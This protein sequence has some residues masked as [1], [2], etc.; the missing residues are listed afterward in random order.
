MDEMTQIPNQDYATFENKHKKAKE[1]ALTTMRNEYKGFEY[2]CI[3]YIDKGKRRGRIS[4]VYTMRKE[5]DRQY[6]QYKEQYE[7]FVKLHGCSMILRGDEIWDDRNKYITTLRVASGSGN[8][9]SQ[10]ELV[11]YDRLKEII[12]DDNCFEKVIKFKLDHLTRLEKLVVGKKSFTRGEYMKTY[13][14]DASFIIMS[15]PS[16]TLIDIGECSFAE[17]GGEWKLSGLDKLKKLRIMS[18]DKESYNFSASPFVIKG[19]LMFE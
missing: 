4:I 13:Y 8:K 18:E 15:C 11:N 7:S 10:F 1:Q 3:Y 14:T 19:G 17:Y 5:L 12:I 2:I 16:L 6:D 9:L